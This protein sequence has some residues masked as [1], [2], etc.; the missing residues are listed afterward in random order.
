MTEDEILSRIA[1]HQRSIRELRAQLAKRRRNPLTVA[2]CREVEHSGKATP[3]RHTGGPGGHGLGLHVKPSGA[4][5]WIQRITLAGRRCDVGLGSFPAVSLSQARD[6]AFENVRIARAGGSHDELMAKLVRPDGKVRKAP[7][8]PTLAEAGTAVIAVQSTA[9]KEGGRTEEAWKRSF[10]TFPALARLPVGRVE[11]PAVLACVEPHWGT[12]RRAMDDL[13]TRLSVVFRWAMAK[14]YRG[15]DPVPAVRATLPKNGRHKGSFAAVPHAELA[16]V[17]GT[18][19]GDS[20]RAAAL[21]LELVALTACRSGEVR[22]ARWG[23]VDFEA[24]TWTIPAERMK[25]GAEH[26]VPLSERALA[27]LGEA[28]AFGGEDL[29]FPAPRGGAL[30]DSSVARVLQGAAPGATVHG[31]RSSFR[32]WCA[33]SGVAREVAEAA[34]AHR[35][36]GVEGAYYRT[37]HL[38]QRAQVMQRW[39]DYLRDAAPRTGTP[40]D[41]R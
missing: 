18:V 22:R 36:G 35:V 20:R 10:A 17:L 40:E 8:E 15:D 37:S 14:G 1:E 2:F 4:K 19:R 5:S 32:D 12:R 24:A 13:L 39:A 9:W 33:E 7:G 3:D 28:R 38:A 30:W 41:G 26:V 11:A 23:E 6:A 29:V 31:L 34:L 27:V 16:R 21:A 25:A